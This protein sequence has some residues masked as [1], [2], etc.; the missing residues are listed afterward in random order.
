MS[1]KGWLTNDQEKLIAKAI[2]KAIDA[3]GLVE[4]VDGYVAKA[5]VTLVDDKL[6]DG[7]NVSSEIKVQVGD[8]ADAALSENVELA[9][10]IGVDI[11]NSLIDIP[12]L[13][14]SSEGVLLEG[15]V[16]LI[17]ASVIQLVKE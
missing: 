13:D 14:E 1:E 9:E 3:K 10:S 7:I 12:G 16:K 4:L 15:A 6:L 5:V 11:I 2:D 17:V 8:L